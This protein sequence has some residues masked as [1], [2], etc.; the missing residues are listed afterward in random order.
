MLASAYESG[1]QAMPQ[2]KQDAKAAR[3]QA[4][5]DVDEVKRRADPT[6]P[7]NA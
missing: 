2:I 6:T 3:E 4:A 1:Q 7:P 5:D